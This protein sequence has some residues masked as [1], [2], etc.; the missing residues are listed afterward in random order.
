M[1]EKIEKLEEA[2]RALK[3]EYDAAWEDFRSA[4]AA[5]RETPSASTDAI[6]GRIFARLDQVGAE[7]QSLHKAI[8]KA[9]RRATKPK[10][11]RRRA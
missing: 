5:H 1:S 6:A 8:K 11:K 3:A 9:S 7:R 10:A 2:R 4:A